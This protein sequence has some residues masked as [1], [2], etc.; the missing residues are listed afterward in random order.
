MCTCLLKGLRQTLTCVLCAV[1]FYS[2]LQDEMLANSPTSQNWPVH[3]EIVFSPVF[4]FPPTSER[5]LL[6][7][8]TRPQS[9]RTNSHPPC[10]HRR[11]RPG[12][13]CHTPT[14]HSSTGHW[15]LTLRR[16]WVLIWLCSQTKSRKKYSNPL[17]IVRSHITMEKILHCKLCCQTFRGM[18][19]DFDTVP[20]KSSYIKSLIANAC[21][22]YILCSACEVFFLTY[23]R[24]FRSPISYS[25]LFI[26]IWFE[27]QIAGS[28]PGKRNAF[29][30]EKNGY[31]VSQNSWDY[32]KN[33]MVKENLYFIIWIKGASVLHLSTSALAPHHAHFVL[34]CLCFTWLPPIC[35]SP[36]SSPFVPRLL[37][38]WS[39]PSLCGES[40]HMHLY[41]HSFVFTPPPPPLLFF[42]LSNLIYQC[43][44]DGF[45]FQGSEISRCFWHFN[46]T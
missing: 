40:L 32:L 11:W 41:L 38:S 24:F 39:S 42:Y 21:T 43:P 20:V 8:V 37:S 12:P 5:P 4:I 18:S 17:L 3:E 10:L 35:P 14:S 26:S 36:G 23:I 30:W 25:F 46:G 2:S 16:V 31:P 27:N 34:N 22:L 15:C 29:S 9:F 1:L 7:V 33:V 28:N 13:I 19:T 44:K 45:G 6:D